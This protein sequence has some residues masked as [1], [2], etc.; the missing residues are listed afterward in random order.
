MLVMPLRAACPGFGGLPGCHLWVAH[1]G[2]TEAAAGEESGL[3]AAS[4]ERPPARQPRLL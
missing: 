3:R 2:E 1:C 4:P